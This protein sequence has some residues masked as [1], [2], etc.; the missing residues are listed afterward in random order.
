MRDAT[1]LHGALLVLL[2]ILLGCSAVSGVSYPAFSLVPAVS[3]FTSR[4]AA[5]S[6]EWYGHQWVAG[7]LFGSDLL[8]DVWSTYDL[9]RNW[10]LS[11][12]LPSTCEALRVNPVV[13]ANTLYLTCSVNSVS[14][15]VHTSTFVNSDPQLLTSSWT[16]LSGGGSAGDDGLHGRSDFNVQRMA[17]PFDSVRHSHP[18]QWLRPNRSAPRPSQR[19]VV[20]VGY[21]Q[22]PTR[23][24]EP[25]HAMAPVHRGRRRVQRPVACSVSRPRRWWIS[26]AGD[27]H[28]RRSGPY[29]PSGS[30]LRRRVATVLAQRSD[31]ARRVSTDVQPGMDCPLS[32]H[33]VVRPLYPV[34]VRR[35]SVRREHSRR[36]VA[37]DGL[38]LHVV[39]SDVV[40]H[41]QGAHA[42]RTPRR[43]PPLLPRRRVRH[44]LHC[45]VRQRGVGG[46]LVVRDR[47]ALVDQMRTTLVCR[48]NVSMDLSGVTQLLCT[49]RGGGACDA[50]GL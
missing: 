46:L 39:S 22:V 24:C 8:T 34:L 33:H 47:G 48:R 3:P 20:A 4:S 25:R 16:A 40:G 36:P 41:R 38:R 50:L 35:N 23:L 11:S 15:S 1:P 18:R 5:F 31:S 2:L 26:W 10:T 28:G 49:S 32:T 9:G 6:F 37:V 19:R 29:H 7:G 13:Y 17:V 44:F 43:R 42:A 12:H 14:T 21:G 27:G 30:L 45:A